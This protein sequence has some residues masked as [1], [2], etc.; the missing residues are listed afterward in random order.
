MPSPL[1]NA[2]PGQRDATSRLL[3]FEPGTV[4][5][6]TVQRLNNHG[7]GVG[8]VPLPA[9]SNGAGWVVLV[10]YVAEGERI[11]ARIV[12]NG[13]K[14][15]VAALVEILDG[16][17]LR[18]QPVCKHFGVCGG[19]QYQHLPYTEQLR[20]KT[21]HVSDGLQRIGGLSPSAAIEITAPAKGSP[22]E[23]HYRSKLTPRYSSSSD[24]SSA[25]GFA[26]VWSHD[27]QIVDVPSCA[28]ATEAI[29]AELGTLR[30]EVRRVLPAAAASGSL[31]LRHTAD[32]G[33]VCDPEQIVTE[34]LGPLRLRFRAG[35]FF[36]N[37]PHVL[38]ALVEHVV[39]AA[40]GG[41]PGEEGACSDLI[42]AY[43]GSGL[44]ALCAAH[45][46]DSCVGI[47]TC[48]GAVEAARAN[49]AANGVAN[50]RFHVGSAEKIFDD[51]GPL[52]GH[53][54]AVVVDPPRKGCSGAF[55]QQ[56]CGFGPRRIVY[57]SC[58]PD[59]QAR[60]LKVLLAAGYVLAGVQP[61][62][63]FPQSRHIESVATLVWP[64]AAEPPRPQRP[65]APAP[66]APR[67][68]GH[69]AARRPRGKGRRRD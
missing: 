41:G 50:A 60:D 34:V 33:V 66:S 6:V 19:C 29:N 35:D 54:T 30:E 7:E 56:L 17:P 47:E 10:P 62:D 12:R 20:V 16:S 4:V 24:G 14:H 22:E 40:C 11:R 23:F 25:V 1:P 45:R 53:R 15:S 51:V 44:F 18:R 69:N 46:F 21:K 57:V 27:A 3:P 38:P 48:A 42:D 28:L 36:Q 52:E 49:A 58:A 68:R 55:L 5:E 67:R 31:L 43:C 8:R 2:R 59:T 37:N 26:S 63:L 61:F 9:A 13:P 64:E 65:A 32:E 39:D